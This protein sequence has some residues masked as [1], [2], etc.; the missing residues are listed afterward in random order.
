MTYYELVSLLETMTNKDNI[1][2]ELSKIQNSVID[3]P[4]L[5]YERFI[6]QVEYLLTRRLKNFMNNFTEKIY[7]KNLSDNEFIL[8]LSLLNNEI[9]NDNRIVN[10]NIIKEENKKRLTESINKNINEIIGQVKKIVD[11]EIQI[12][13]LEKYYRKEVDSNELQ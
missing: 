11:S 2:E 7:M 4:G 10:L 9:Q 6:D 12:S 8:E 3:L 5:R 1:E 13:E